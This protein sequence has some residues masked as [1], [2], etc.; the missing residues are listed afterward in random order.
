M[1]HSEFS[2]NSSELTD[3]KE[4]KNILG[5]SVSKKNLDL[6]KTIVF[7]GF[8]MWCPTIIQ[9][10]TSNFATQLNLVQQHPWGN[11][12]GRIYIQCQRN[13]RISKKE[14]TFWGFHS[15]QK[16]LNLDTNIFADSLHLSSGAYN[17]NLV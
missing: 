5:H 11:I 9:F 6:H 12:M 7:N 10:R 8:E 13:W 15:V 17:E 16:N 3:L 14:K 4:S 2:Y 1:C